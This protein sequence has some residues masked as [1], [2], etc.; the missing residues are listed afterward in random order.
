MYKRQ[1]PN[2]ILPCY[3]Y[4]S[5]KIFLFCRLAEIYKSKSAVMKQYLCTFTSLVCLRSFLQKLF[6][7]CLSPQILFTKTRFMSVP[8]S[9]R[10]DSLR[11]HYISTS[12][13]G[14]WSQAFVFQNCCISSFH[15][16]KSVLPLLHKPTEPNASRYFN[17][18]FLYN[19][20]SYTCLLYTSRCV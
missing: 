6:T 8:N 17:I 10:P 9:V 5:P 18:L 14:V 15:F 3:S 19:K 13:V 1:I 7:C 16:N 11:P 12:T 20:E 4:Y 2:S